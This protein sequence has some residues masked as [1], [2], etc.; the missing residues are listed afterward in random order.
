VGGCCSGRLLRRAASAVVVALIAVSAN[1]FGVV[2]THSSAEAE[3]AARE[4]QDVRDRANDASQAMFDAESELDRSGLEI[5]AAEDDLADANARADAMR[6][7]LQ[8]LAAR[9]F[10]NG[11]AASMPL[12]IDLDDANEEPTAERFAAVARGGAAADLDELGLLRS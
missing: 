2:A 8:A 5:A 12:L 10:V 1:P 3:Q 4:I 6:T 7:E 9:S 11:G